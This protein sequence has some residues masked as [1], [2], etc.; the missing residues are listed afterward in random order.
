MNI[1]EKKII[2]DTIFESYYLHCYVANE[3]KTLRVTDPYV[4]MLE[5]HRSNAEEKKMMKKKS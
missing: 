3:K 2:L 5:Y 1:R 4:D